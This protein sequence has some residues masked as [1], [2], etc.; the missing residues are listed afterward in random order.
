MPKISIVMS[1]YNGEKYLRQSIE[2]I[3]SQS[4]KDFEFIIINDGSTDNSLKIIEEFKKKDERIELI[5]RENKGLIYS[6]NEGVKS[7]KGEYIA[8]M[9]ADDVSMPNRLEKQ[10][11]YVEEG[12]LAVCGSWANGIDNKGIKTRFLNYPPKADRIR[13]FTILHNP[14]IHTSVMFRKDIYEK[15]GGYRSFFK[16]IEDYEL[17]TRIVFKYKTDNITESLL[18][19]RFHDDQIT[20]KN[21]LFMRF[22]GV[23][24]RFLSIIRFIFRF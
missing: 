11:K 7:A 13:F 16:H 22:M 24:V 5:S 15:V 6:L 20:K 23:L 17:W 4:F 18:E 14:F 10:L 19:Y 3:L 21:N 2:S 8:R 1:V 9:D 12:G